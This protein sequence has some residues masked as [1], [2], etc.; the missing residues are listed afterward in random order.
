MNNN[1]HFSLGRITDY[2]INSTQSLAGNHRFYLF[3]WTPWHW[4]ALHIGQ[5]C[6]ICRF[7]ITSHPRQVCR[8][9]I[10]MLPWGSFKC[11]GCSLSK[12]VFIPPLII[13][14][15]LQKKCT[16][17]SSFSWWPRVTHPDPRS[18]QVC[19]MVFGETSKWPR[20]KIPYGSL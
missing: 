15:P 4:L 9:N 13:Y 10:F 18:C 8:I 19:K 5:E 16:L 2:G 17:I 7:Y 20:F 3:F 12:T 11:S 6:F 1:C 14:I